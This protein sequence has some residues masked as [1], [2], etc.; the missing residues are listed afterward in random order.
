[1]LPVSGRISNTVPLTAYENVSNVP[2][3][4]FDLACELL[5]KIYPRYPC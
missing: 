1:M 4:G 5:R 2:G 3:V